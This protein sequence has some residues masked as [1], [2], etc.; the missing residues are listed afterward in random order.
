[1]HTC[2]FPEGAGLRFHEASTGE[3]AKTFLGDHADDVTLLFSDVAMPG[4]TD[5]FAL[6]YYIA[7]HWT[8][9]EIVMAR[10]SMKPCPGDM[11]DKTTFIGSPFNDRMVNRHLR[12]KNAGPQ[13]TRAAQALGLAVFC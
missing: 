10:G 12:E 7:E 9:I 8:W 1:M 13:A 3:E 11:P 2:D 6:A 4:H 5:G